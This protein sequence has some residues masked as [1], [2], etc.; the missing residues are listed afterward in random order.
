MSS[1][2]LSRQ[3]ASVAISQ[4]NWSYRHIWFLALLFYAV[5]VKTAERRYR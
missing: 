4:E 5:G 2:T 1:D 3:V